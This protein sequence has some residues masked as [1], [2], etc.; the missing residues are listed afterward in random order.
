MKPIDRAVAKNELARINAALK[1]PHLLIGGLAVQCY[2]PARN[3]KDI[4]LVCDFGTAQM[5]LDTLYPS[6]DWKVIDKQNDEYRPSFNI[7]HKVDDV[8]V[9]I[10]GPKISERDPYD[11]IDWTALMV[12]G[13][14][15]PGRIGPLENIIVPG[16][17]Q[18]TC[19]T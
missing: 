11:H 7:T 17:C 5:L 15:F 10:F 2:H 13:S 3:S 9:I 16:E 8:G 4:D 1:K 19:V 14:A 18:K 6:R 12:G